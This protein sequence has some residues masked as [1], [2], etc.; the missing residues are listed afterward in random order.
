MILVLSMQRTRA[1]R[2][3]GGEE[4]LHKN[5]VLLHSLQRGPVRGSERNPCST[6]PGRSRGRCTLGQ[7]NVATHLVHASGQT[8]HE[9][10]MKRTFR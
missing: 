10:R 8:S 3:L 5:V 6:V 2:T 4:W 7:I 1:G 9:L